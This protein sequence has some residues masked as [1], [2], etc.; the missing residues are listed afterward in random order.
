MVKNIFNRM[1]FL[2][3]FKGFNGSD[4]LYFGGVVAAAKDAHVDKLVFGQI[5]IFHDGLSVDLSQRFFF[6]V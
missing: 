4:S 6:V 2:D 1:E 5:E 3:E